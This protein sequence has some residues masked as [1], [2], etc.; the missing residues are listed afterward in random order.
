MSRLLD[1]LGLRIAAPAAGALAR[2]FPGAGGLF[3]GLPVAPAVPATLGHA[4]EAVRAFAHRRQR[5]RG[6]QGQEQCQGQQ[7][8]KYL[9]HVPFSPLLLCFFISAIFPIYSRT[10]IFFKKLLGFFITV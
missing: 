7:D 4:A 8:S 3:G 10:D 6:Q 1:A 9:L 2:P 5:R